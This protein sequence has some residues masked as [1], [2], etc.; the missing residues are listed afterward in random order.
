MTLIPEEPALPESQRAEGPLVTRYEDISQTGKLLLD[1]IA[2]ILGPAIWS[3]LRDH[4][5]TEAMQA[6]GVIPLLY[7][8]VIE[9]EEGPVSINSRIQGK[10]SFELAHTAREDGSIDRLVLNM[11]CSAYGDAGRTYGPPPPNAGE[12]IRLGRVFAEHVL[13]RPF[14][15]KEARKVIRLV[16]PGLPEVPPARYE[17][18]PIEATLALPEGAAFLDEAFVADAAPVTFGIDHTDS[19][20]HVNSLVYPRLFIEAGLRRLW[21]HK[22]RGALAARAA[23][24]VYRKPCFAGERARA[25]VKAYVHGEEMGV[26]GMLVGEEEAAGAL[27]PAKARCYA[28]IVF[29]RE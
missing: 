6:D 11:W 19:N 8:L 4:A 9:S 20:Q 16:G 15:P 21:E 29:V 7:R 17:S 23:E 22:K 27:D 26:V 14:A 10:G 13:T 2:I 1:A 25:H 18:R 12:T 28:R 3:V 5:S 24:L